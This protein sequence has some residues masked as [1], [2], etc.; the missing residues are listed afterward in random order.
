MWQRAGWSPA[1]P[2]GRWQQGRPTPPGS[3]CRGTQWPLS[4][5]P[6]AFLVGHH[7]KLNSTAALPNVQEGRAWLASGRH[8]LTDQRMIR[9]R[10]TSSLGVGRRSPI[11]QPC[12]LPPK[13]ASTARQRPALTWED[14][15]SPLAVTIA[16]PTL[17]ALGVSGWPG[18]DALTPQPPSSRGGRHWR[19][20][21]ALM[22]SV[23]VANRSQSRRCRGP[24]RRVRPGDVRFSFAL[25]QRR[26]RG[27]HR[28]VARYESKIGAHALPEWP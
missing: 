14:V 4:P 16:R 28:I 24:R 27:R 22:A 5:R 8:H 1:L 11:P 6:P 15:W 17:A 10:I 21:S 23:H 7:R 2:G 12:P 19:G 13:P 26:N 9:H 3:T 25:R 18:W 20:T